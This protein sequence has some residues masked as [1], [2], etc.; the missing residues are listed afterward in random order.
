[1][2]ATS[3]NPL[4][5]DAPSRAAAAETRFVI[6]DVPW[7]AYVA[8]RDALDDHAG[9]RLTYLEGALELMSPSTD[10]VDYR[11]LIARLLEA[12]AE[13]KDVDLRGFGGAT[14]RKEA[15]KRGLEPDECYSI[16]PLGEVPHIA[17]EVVV[18]SGLVDK[19]A[20]YQGLGVEE[21]WVWK[22]GK[23]TIM[24]LAGDA[25]AERPASARLP[26]L[27]VAHLASFVSLGA[28]QTR[29]VKEYRRS[30]RA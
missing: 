2:A 28:N 27:D 21:V 26:A 24:H 30:L 11:A 29:V 14:F 7:P 8:L 4:A 23:L 16:G 13:E 25:Y 12:F 3:V 18:T 22:G 6:Y 5:P 1:M 9:L 20:V 19:L 17:I 15:T 10:H